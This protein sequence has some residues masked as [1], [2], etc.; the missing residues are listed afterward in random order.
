MEE[1]G[2]FQGIMPPAI[3][4][5]D[6]EGGIDAGKTKRFLQ[7]LIDSGVH[8]L[9]VAGSTGEYSLMT[10]EQRR[11][12]IDVG[13]EAANGK[14]P[15]F[16]GTGHNSTRIAV[17]LSKYAE[18]AGADGVVVSLPHYPRPTQEALYRHYQ[19]ISE[20]IDIPLYVY[21]WPGQYVVDIEP[22]TVAR[23]AADGY[24]QGI[25]DSTHDVD[26][27]AKIVKLTGERIVVLEGFETKIFA[28]L[29]LGADGAICTMGNILPAELVSIYELFR[30]GKMT[31]ARDKQM[32]VFGLAEV[33][34]ARED[35][36]LLKEGLKMLGLDVGDALMPTSEVPPELRER[37]RAELVKLGKLR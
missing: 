4:V 12:I 34:S 19:A 2:R 10:M 6:S 17:E 18:V 33:L 23:L 36:Q 20:A 25:K 37:L 29:C 21:S 27:T 9:F 8:G 16:A 7:H 28:A 5:F 32:S 22:E 13:V 26:H 30:E 14:V 35:M 31:E 3:T 11:Q 1:G 24:V 15:L